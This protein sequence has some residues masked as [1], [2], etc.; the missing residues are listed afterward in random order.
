MN[1]SCSEK[2]VAEVEL[3]FLWRRHDSNVRTT[4][5]FD[6]QS[7][8]F[9]HFA[10]PPF[11]CEFLVYTLGNAT[12]VI[13]INIQDNRPKTPKVSLVPP[14]GALSDTRT[15][16]LVPPQRDEWGTNYYDSS[17]QLPYYQTHRP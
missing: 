17:L 11:W 15:L 8:A 2:V 7:N 1:L 3:Y 5:R 10:T 9:G 6:L 4:L 16:P 13:Y 12:T 14:S